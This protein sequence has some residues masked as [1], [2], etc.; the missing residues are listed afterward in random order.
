MKRIALLPLAS[1]ALAAC[2]EATRPDVDSPIA[3]PQFS[4]VIGTE[5]Q[6]T[7]DPSDQHFSAISGDR[8][9]WEDFRNGNRDIF[10]F[11]LSVPWTHKIET[12]L[13]VLDQGGTH[14]R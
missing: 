11:D 3:P 14:D 13:K 10:M 12:A 8:I 4:I 7:T 2:E 6:I 1:L 9:V 5:T